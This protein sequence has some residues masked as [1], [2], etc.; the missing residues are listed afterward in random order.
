MWGERGSVE[1]YAVAIV[2]V[3]V[4]VAIRAL[5]A[6]FFG[7]VS[8]FLLLHGAVIVAARYGGRGP[9]VA[10]IALATAA[11]DYVFVPPYRSLALTAGA[12]VELGVFVVE[13]S[14]VAA[15]TV[16][17]KEARAQ[18]QACAERCARSEEQLRKL[19]K[20]HRALSVSNETLVRAEDEGVLLEEICRAIVEDAG[21][22]MCWVGRAEHDE[23]K[24]VRPIARAGYDE[25]YVDTAAVTWADTERGRSAVGTAIR[26]ARSEVRPDIAVDPAFAPWR[27]EAL[28]RGYASAIALPLRVHGRVSGALGIYAA[29]KDA[30]DADAVRLLTDLGNDLAYG[31]RALRTRASVAAERARLETTVML[32]PVAVAVLAGPDHVVRLANRRWFALGHGIEALGRPLRDI[33][34]EAAAAGALAGLDEAYATGEPREVS[35]RPVPA[36]ARTDPSRCASSTWRASRSAAPAA[37]S[38]TSSSPSPT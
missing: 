15:L 23:Q 21:Y 11:A 16:A 30:F 10:A 33:L 28:K 20:A 35:E 36:G 1:R 12:A 25:G 27:A 29:E 38:P 9:A 8:P 26:M 22:R 2:A 14:L 31:I 34:P 37:S 7:E 32:A 4:A 6:H 24:S 17:T 3:A 5:P 13:A 18:A 19:N